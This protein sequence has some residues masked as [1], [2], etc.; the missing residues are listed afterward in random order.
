MKKWPL[1]LIALIMAN[2]IPLIGV[3]ANGW[4]VLNVMLVFVGE[5][6]IIGFYNV[7]K[8]L[9]A[10]GRHKQVKIPFFIVHFSGFCFVHAMV[11]TKLIGHDALTDWSA[12]KL[13][14]PE[15]VGLLVT[16]SMMLSLSCLL[17]SHGVS[18]YLNYIRGGEYLKA[19][20]L[21][22]FSLPYKRV[23]VMHVALILGALL[24]V[25]LGSA[26]WMLCMLILLKLIIDIR[27]HLKEHQQP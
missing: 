1:P 8:M 4:S 2:L 24:A 12:G 16:A 20:V 7:L 17:I 19:T 21:N 15:D 10:D 27:Q 18:F 6:V 25:K 22:L 3:L 13:K 11:V 14:F 23:V 5:T 9:M 26:V